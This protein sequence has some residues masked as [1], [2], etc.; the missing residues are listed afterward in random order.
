[1]VS[2]DKLRA[3]KLLS[4]SV[5]HFLAC[6]Y[7]E[8]LSRVLSGVLSIGGVLRRVLSRV[9]FLSFHHVRKH[10]VAMAHP[11][12]RELLRTEG[13]RAKKS[14]PHRG[15]GP[16]SVPFFLCP[17]M[18]R[19]PQ[20]WGTILAVFWVLLVANPLPPTPFETADF[21]SFCFFSSSVGRGHNREEHTM[22]RAL[23]H[24]LL[25]CF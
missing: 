21:A 3:C 16:F 24:A 11:D 25:H 1:M 4:L 14:F 8:V 9:L 15:F 10:S 6:V 20:F 13:V 7:P 2:S 19:R 22:E 18:S 17:L 23:V 12:F 5:E